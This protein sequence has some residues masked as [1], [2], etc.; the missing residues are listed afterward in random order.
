MVKYQ[1]K[2]LTYFWLS[3][4]NIPIFIKHYTEDVCNINISHQCPLASMMSSKW[5]NS[6]NFVNKRRYWY[7]PLEIEHRSAEV[8]CFPI[9]RKKDGKYTFLLQIIDMKRQSSWRHFYI[10]TFPT[11]TFNMIILTSILSLNLVKRT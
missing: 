5:A 8:G 2:I 9:K 1:S 4:Y 7:L 11:V 3:S 10:I 6:R